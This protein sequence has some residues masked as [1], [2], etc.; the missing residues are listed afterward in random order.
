[1]EAEGFEKRTFNVSAQARVF[2]RVACDRE[3]DCRFMEP[4]A[5]K[6]IDSLSAPFHKPFEAIER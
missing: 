5:G 3:L 4:P 6:Q 1:M 2:V